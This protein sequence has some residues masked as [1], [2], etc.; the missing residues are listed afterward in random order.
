MLIIQIEM[1]RRLAAIRSTG[2]QRML[3][4]RAAVQDFVL[5]HDVTTIPT[6]RVL[7][8]LLERAGGIYLGDAAMYGHPRGT[9]MFAC[10]GCDCYKCKKERRNEV[11]QIMEEMN[12][13]ETDDGRE[14]EN[15]Q[16]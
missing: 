2:I 7:E 13:Q 3:T 12:E 15:S 4:V 14:C 6:A 1:E 16:T 5:Q 10:L 8:A 11:V 9:L